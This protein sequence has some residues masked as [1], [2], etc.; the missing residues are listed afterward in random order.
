[1]KQVKMLKPSEQT[2]T[3]LLEEYVACQILV[4]NMKLLLL[5]RQAFYKQR[6]ELLA[7]THL[8]QAEEMHNNRTEQSRYDD[9]F[10]PENLNSVKIVKKQ[11]IFT[12]N[13]YHFYYQIHSDGQSNQNVC[14][15]LFVKIGKKIENIWRFHRFSDEVMK[16]AKSIA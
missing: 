1:M 6:Q 15:S 7:E 14:W 2:H 9:P 8:A 11:A 10:L 5:K 13:R 3:S 16:S 12:V 4:R